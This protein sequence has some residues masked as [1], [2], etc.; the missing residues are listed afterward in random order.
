[1]PNNEWWESAEFI[2]YPGM[3]FNRPNIPKILAHHRKMIVKE[4]RGEIKRQYKETRERFAEGKTGN[5]RVNAMVDTILSL[6]CL[7]EN[8]WYGNDI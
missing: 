4:I 6:P 3:I 8:E 1:M 5:E 2:D 7:K